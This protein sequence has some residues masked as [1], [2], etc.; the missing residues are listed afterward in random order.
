MTASSTTLHHRST[1]FDHNR[2]IPLIL[3]IYAEEHPSLTLA[4]PPRS[5]TA[6]SFAQTLF[7]AMNVSRL[8]SPYSTEAE[9]LQQLQADKVKRQ[10]TVSNGKL[11]VGYSAPEYA[12]RGQSTRKADVYSFGVLLVKRVSGRSNRNT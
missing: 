9:L 10:M 11:S 6:S 8:W 5:P 2:W 4:A 12:I 1:R 7:S 3:C